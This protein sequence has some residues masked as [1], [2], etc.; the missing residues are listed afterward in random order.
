MR[1]SFIISMKDELIKKKQE[2]LERISL[3]SGELDADG[4][5]MDLVQTAALAQVSLDI[6]HK[7]N[8]E[9]KLIQSA[10]AKIQE[11]AYGLCEDCGEDINEKRLMFNPNF[12][13]CVSCAEEQEKERK[14]GTQYE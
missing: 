8:Y 11:G 13:C 12:K 3:T 4:D 1:H 6:N 10:L 14:R 9:L 2:L 7:L 5:E